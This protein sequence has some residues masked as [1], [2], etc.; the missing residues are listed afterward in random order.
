M[1]ALC[2]SFNANITI[3]FERP[4]APLLVEP[5]MAR[6]GLSTHTHTHQYTHQYTPLVFL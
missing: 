3:R 6:V 4:G 2:E 1:V 5:L